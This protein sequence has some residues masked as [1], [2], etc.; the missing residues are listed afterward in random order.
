MIFDLEQKEKQLLERLSVSEKFR[1]KCQEEY[2]EARRKYK[3]FYDAARGLNRGHRSCNES[4]ITEDNEGKA[5]I[6][7]S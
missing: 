7:I 6:F 4:R 2:E 1:I 3:S 5:D